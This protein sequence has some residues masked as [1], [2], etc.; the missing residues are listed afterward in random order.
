VSEPSLIE[1]EHIEVRLGGQSVLHNVSLRIEPRQIISLIGPNGAGKTTLVRALLG[2][3]PPDA[4][5]VRRRPGL[6]VAYLPQRLK[7]DP[8]LPITVEGFL[9]LSAGNDP[10]AVQ[11]ALHE[12]GVYPLRKSPMQSISGG[13][14]Q[15]VMLAR[16][17]LR[18]PQLLVLDEPD[19]G[20]DVS[21]QESLYGLITSIRDRY[22]CAILMVSHDLHFVMAATDHVVCLQHHVCCTGHPHIVAGHPEF[23]RMFGRPSKNL[24][25]YTHDHDHEHNLHGDVVDD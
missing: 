25:V 12:A 3:L 22:G 10:A 8:A 9:R 11:T 16:C 21:G 7:I 5:H 14:F 15:R 17:L 23:L 24:A 6:T 2:L 13:E 19:Q 1:A 20:M 4:G 18:N